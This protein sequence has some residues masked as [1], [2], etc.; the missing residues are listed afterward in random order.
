MSLHSFCV[1]CIQRMWGLTMKIKMRGERKLPCM[2]PH[3]I[4]IRR[5]NPEGVQNC[6]AAYVYTLATIRIKSSGM[7]KKRCMRPSCVW[8][9]NVKACVKSRY[10]IRMSLLRVWASSMHKPSWVIALEQEWSALNPSFPG[11][12]FYGLLRSLR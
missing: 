9:A 6:V 8:S 7:P 10:A 4:S 12:L 2:V 5:V 11:W 3:R 1:D